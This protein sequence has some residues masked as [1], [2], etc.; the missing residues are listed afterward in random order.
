[1][2]EEVRR[3]GEKEGRGGRE[4]SEGGREGGGGKRMLADHVKGN[5]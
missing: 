4:K 3:E 1:M 2:S 5:S